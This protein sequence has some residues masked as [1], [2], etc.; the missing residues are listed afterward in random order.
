MSRL[1]PGGWMDDPDV[2][3]L[4]LVLLHGGLRRHTPCKELELSPIEAPGDARQVGD[5][6][7]LCPVVGEDVGAVGL[8]AIGE[9]S[10]DRACIGIGEAQEPG[11][12]NDLVPRVLL[13]GG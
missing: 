8:G 2:D 10:G 5:V 9:R 13:D 3:R 4:E 1:A 6:G 7:A 11:P 12:I